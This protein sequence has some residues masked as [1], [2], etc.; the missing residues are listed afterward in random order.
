VKKHEVFKLA[1]PKKRVDWYMIAMTLD[2]LIFNRVLWLFVLYF[3]NPGILPTVVGLDLLVSFIICLYVSK[4]TQRFDVIW[5]FPLY[6]WI[7]YL[8]FYAYT[9]AFVEIIILKKTLLD[10]KKVKRYDFESQPV[11]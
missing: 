1:L 9:R 3:T 4:K 2:A 8:N 5:K 6:Y 10:W 7:S 11:K